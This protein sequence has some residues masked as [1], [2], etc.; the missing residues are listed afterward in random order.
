MRIDIC[1]C[2]RQ[3]TCNENQLTSDHTE[4]VNN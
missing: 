1:D 2:I 4:Q 3:S